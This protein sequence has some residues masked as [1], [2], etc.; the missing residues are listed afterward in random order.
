[1]N[2]LLMPGNRT[3][4]CWHRVWRAWHPPMWA[5]CT[6]WARRSRQRS[7]PTRSWRL[8]FTPWCASTRSFPRVG[9]AGVQCCL[10]CA[11]QPIL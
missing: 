7:C 3:L 5:T 4:H 8:C 11:R 2:A 1:V 10:E 6:T 9:H